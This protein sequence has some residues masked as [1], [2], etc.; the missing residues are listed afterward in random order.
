MFARFTFI[1]MVVLLPFAFC[2]LLFLLAHLFASIESGMNQACGLVTETRQVPTIH[3]GHG[4]EL[5]A[6][7]H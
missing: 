2:L 5:R 3:C 1:A 7:L 6:A 4:P